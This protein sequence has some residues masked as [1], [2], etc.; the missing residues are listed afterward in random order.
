M[1]V[2]SSRYAVGFYEKL[3]F[4]PLDKEQIANGIKFTPMKHVF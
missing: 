3:G 4:I 1:T 2:N